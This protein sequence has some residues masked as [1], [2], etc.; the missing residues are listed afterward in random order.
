MHVYQCVIYRGMY[1]NIPYLERVSFRCF[2][3]H[4][5]ASDEYSNSRN[6]IVYVCVCVSSFSFD[7]IVVSIWTFSELHL[8]KPGEYN[9]F[10]LFST[11]SG[12]I[13]ISFVTFTKFFASL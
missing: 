1:L 13:H 7:T 11:K 3:L 4:C 2:M 8:T 5:T 12:I 10:H 9:D 6:S